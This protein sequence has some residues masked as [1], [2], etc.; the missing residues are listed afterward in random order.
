VSAGENSIVLSDISR[1]TVTAEQNM[2]GHAFVCGF[3]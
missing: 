2:V 1:H 3:P